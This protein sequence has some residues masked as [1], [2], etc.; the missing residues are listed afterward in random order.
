[1]EAT[2]D[3]R[4]ESGEARRNR[5]REAV[6]ELSGRARSTELFRLVLYPGAFLAVLGFALMLI[7]WAGAARTHRQI[8]QIPYLISGGLVGL[9]LVIV[10]AL[11]LSTAMWMAGVQRQQQ[12]AEERHA[13]QLA[14]LTA[15]V[16][17]LQESTSRNGRAPLRATTATKAKTR[18]S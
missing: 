3:L 13:Q 7:G 14:E 1:V 5:F 9:G 6:A 2:T 16:T 10:G 4:M 11:L 12:Q 15:L 17:A 18:S 8:E